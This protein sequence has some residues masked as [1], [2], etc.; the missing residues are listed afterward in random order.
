MGKTKKL[1]IYHIY[2]DIYINIYIYKT[3]SRMPPSYEQNKT[4]IYNWRAN[5]KERYREIAKISARRLA[6]FKKV[7]R[8]FR[9]ILID[10]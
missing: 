4:H 9:N 1:S 5:N 7:W 10:E 2:I 6:P 8:E 3:I